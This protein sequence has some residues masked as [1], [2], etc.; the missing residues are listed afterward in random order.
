MAPGTRSKV[1]PCS[2]PMSFGSKCAI[3]NKA[4]VTLL[5]LGASPQ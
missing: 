1:A 2:N 5:E 4:L 3:L